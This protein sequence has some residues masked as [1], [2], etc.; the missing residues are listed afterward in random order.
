MA[1]VN[2]Y[3]RYYEA[4]FECNGTQRCGA[5][6]LLISDSESGHIKY[7]AAVAFIPHEDEEDFRVPYDAYFSRIVYEA[8]GR[9]SKKKEETL[10]DSLIQTIDELI[11]G[12]GGSVFWDKP[13]TQEKLG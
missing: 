11:E 6:V 9:R 3:Q 4:A 13:L 8:D 10:L 12:T 5:S 7:T 2:I 1:E